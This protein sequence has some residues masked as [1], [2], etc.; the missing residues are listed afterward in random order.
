[1]NY[2]DRLHVRIFSYVLPRSWNTHRPAVTPHLVTSYFSLSNC[3]SRSWSRLHSHHYCTC[4]TSIG[5]VTIT[6]SKYHVMNSVPFCESEW[7]VRSTKKGADD[8]YGRAE[9]RQTSSN[10][11]DYLPGDVPH[12]STQIYQEKTTKQVL[13]G[14]FPDLKRSMRMDNDR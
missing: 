14:T 1:M 10:S 5:L 8:R 4:R 6:N 7:T 13:L 3:T 9:V 12:R 11:V 2:H